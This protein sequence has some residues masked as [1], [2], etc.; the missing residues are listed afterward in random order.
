M[1]HFAKTLFLTTKFT[2]LFISSWTIRCLTTIHSHA[3]WTMKGYILD[4]YLHGRYEDG[5]WSWTLFWPCPLARPAK[6]VP[7][8]LS[9]SPPPSLTWVNGWAQVDFCSDSSNLLLSHREKAEACEI[10]ER[11]CLASSDKENIKL[12]YVVHEHF[13]CIKHL[14]PWALPPCRWNVTW[15]VTSSSSR[16]PSHPRWP[17]CSRGY[18]HLPTPRRARHQTVGQ[19]RSRHT[20]SGVTSGCRW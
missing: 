12:F 5:I 11:K 1:L 19:T 13:P 18:H 2:R 4:K 10:E 9:V 8:N 16:P 7:S 6:S 14:E 20:D 17:G 3:C 15:P